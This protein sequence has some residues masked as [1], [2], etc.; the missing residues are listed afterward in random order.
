MLARTHGQPA[1]PTRLGKE[2][3]VFVYRIRQQLKLLE[4]VFSYILT[5]INFYKIPHTMKFGGA[6]GQFNAHVVSYPDI[7]WPTAA[8]KSVLH[9]YLY[10]Y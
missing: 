7:D 5:F 9:V 3:M 6:T 10:L 2:I 1:T 8:D 4:H